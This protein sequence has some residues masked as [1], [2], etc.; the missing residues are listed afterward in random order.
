MK[1]LFVVFAVA[2]TSALN[3]Q[4]IPMSPMEAAE[5]DAFKSPQIQALVASG[6]S[7][8]ELKR[9][10][11]EKALADNPVLKI[12]RTSPLD[13]LAIEDKTLFRLALERAGTSPTIKLLREQ[14]AELG[15]VIEGLIDEL[16][17]GY[18]NVQKRIQELSTVQR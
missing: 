5:N 7:W 1:I 8:F 4:S 3:A 13:R 15:L 17:P 14:Q 9:A 2:M 11:T 6:A 12:S 16:T 10:V 18:K